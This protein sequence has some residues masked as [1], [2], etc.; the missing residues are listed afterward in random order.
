ML[1][2]KCVVGG[3]DVSDFV[4]SARV[5]QTTDPNDED[6]IDLT[7]ANTRNRF[8]GRF[9]TQDRMEMTVFNEMRSCEGSKT[10]TIK[11]FYGEVVRVSYD[12]PRLV[13]IEGACLMGT[14]VDNI[15]ELKIYPT[16]T[17]PSTI[18]KDLIATH[19]GLGTPI[20]D[21]TLD[22]PIDQEMRFG[23]DQDYLSALSQL[24]ALTGSYYF[25]DESGQFWF[26]DPKMRKG[27]TNLTG[28]LLNADKTFDVIGHCNIVKVVGGSMFKPEEPGSE[29][30]THQQIQAV[31]VNPDSISAHGELVAVPI[32]IPYGNEPLVRVIS[33]NINEFFKARDDIARPVVVGRAPALE[34]FVYYLLPDIVIPDS[35]DSGSYAVT[36]AALVSGLVTGRTVEYS[37]RGLIS[38]L[39]VATSI[40]EMGLGYV[41]VSETDPDEKA[42]TITKMSDEELERAL[43]GTGGGGSGGR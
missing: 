42:E 39:Q 7:L 37:T 1:T 6:K 15:K 21:I 13:K 8:T 40:E 10:L 11:L 24:S 12:S 14:L 3:V 28:H 33:N 32:V 23:I 19:G 43:E 18:V 25:F 34:S 16:G 29:I 4:V 9:L 35:C 41:N 2:H 38:E 17:Y 36:G 22:R 5:Q 20:V 26:V 27:Y 30:P 31:A